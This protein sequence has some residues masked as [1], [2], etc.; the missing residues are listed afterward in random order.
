MTF[1][2]DPTLPTD[3]DWVRFIIGDRVVETAS[4][5]DGEIDA[6]LA[7]EA[8]KYLAAA[9]CGRIILARGRGGVT[10]KS[11]DGLSLSYDSSPE[12][13]YGKHLTEIHQKGCELLL[14]KGRRFFQVL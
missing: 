11:V 3:R 9:R 13:A 6:V 14:P 5:D 7:Q 1:S 4:L 8:N 2:Y 12:G 10:S